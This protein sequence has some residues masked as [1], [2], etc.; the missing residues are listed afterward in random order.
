MLMQHLQSNPKPCASAV[1]VQQFG[2]K[3][4]GLFSAFNKVCE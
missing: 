1:L 4:E 3:F 2:L